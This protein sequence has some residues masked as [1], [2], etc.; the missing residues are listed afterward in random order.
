MPSTTPLIRSLHYNLPHNLPP[1]LTPSALNEPQQLRAG[2]ILSIALP[3]QLTY[4][5]LP[6]LYFG[7]GMLVYFCGPLPNNCVI[8]CTLRDYLHRSGD[9]LGFLVIASTW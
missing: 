9:G 5:I 6:G 7:T 8:S 2:M 4:Q 3:S 1:S